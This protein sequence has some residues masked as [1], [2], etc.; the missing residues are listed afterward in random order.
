MLT[1]YLVSDSWNYVRSLVKCNNIITT[2]VISVPGCLDP[3]Y[4]NDSTNCNGD[5]L[6]VSTH[7]YYCNKDEHVI[8]VLISNPDKQCLPNHTGILCGACK[9]GHSRVLSDIYECKQGCSNTNLYF[10]IPFFLASGIL[11]VISIIMLNM[12]VAEGTLNG[13]LLYAMVIQTHGTYFPEHPSKFKHFC[14]IF[15]SW[16]N[17]SFGI[18]ACLYEGMDGYQHM[19]SVYSSQL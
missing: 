7:C 2:K 19:D 13:L 11:L 17:L 6:I 18:K 14:W 10:L 8:N 5:I 1:K 12:T 4:Q 16:I 3:K 9:E 15:I